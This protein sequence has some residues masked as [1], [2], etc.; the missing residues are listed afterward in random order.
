MKH[1]LTLLVVAVPF[2]IILWGFMVISIQ[3]RGLS[4]F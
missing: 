1:Q 4:G 2:S 3:A